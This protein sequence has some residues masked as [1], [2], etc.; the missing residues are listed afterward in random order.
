MPM[1]PVRL[2]IARGRGKTQPTYVHVND[3]YP[4]PLPECDLEF[5]INGCF[6]TFTQL[7]RWTAVGNIMNVRLTLKSPNGKN[8]ETDL[9]QDDNWRKMR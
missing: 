9:K 3:S 5:H 4:I 6:Y 2:R 1:I 7:R 8:L